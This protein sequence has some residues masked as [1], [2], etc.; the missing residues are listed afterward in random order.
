MQVHRSKHFSD[1]YRLFSSTHHHS[2]NVCVGVVKYV[3]LFWRLLV[4]LCFHRYS[5]ST[6]EKDGSISQR[7]LWRR[8]IDEEME[9]FD[10]LKV[11]VVLS[12]HPLQ[13][14]SLI[15]LCIPKNEEYIGMV[16]TVTLYNNIICQMCR[17]LEEG[18]Q[19]SLPRI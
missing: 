7:T 3:T 5:M 18:P 19:R 9:D 12:E 6:K 13:E 1:F 17:Q 14:P 8:K 2:S 15:F 10:R 16:F 11:K 4:V